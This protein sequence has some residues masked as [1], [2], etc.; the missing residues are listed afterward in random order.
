MHVGPPRSVADLPGVIPVFP[1]A[2]VLLLPHGRL[3]L[4]IFEPR[5]LAMTLD[6]LATPMRL[7]GMIQPTEPEAPGRPPK[8]YGT[9]CAGRIAS[10]SETDDGRYLITL[11][12]VCRFKLAE[13]IEPLNGYRRIVPDF[14]IFGG[15]LAPEPSY[16]LDRQRLGK[17]LKRY[18]TAHSIAADWR[19][20][21]DAPDDRLITTLAMICPFEPREKQALLETPE[22]AERARLLIA[23]L[24]MAAAG[25][26]PENARH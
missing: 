16:P 18:F 24:E 2:G 21:S 15:D 20:I 14:A 11:S 5:Y 8:L 4:N 13:E 17:A 6:A 1:L 9:G 19:S 23:L 10:F 22:A 26:G 3:P 25:G 7:I 12:G